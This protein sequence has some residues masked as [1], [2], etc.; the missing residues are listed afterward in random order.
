MI[1]FCF[2]QDTKET[3]LRQI[4]E[5]NLT[6]NAKKLP[7]YPLLQKMVLTPQGLREYTQEQTVQKCGTDV[8]AFFVTQ[9]PQKVNRN[10]LTGEMTFIDCANIRSFNVDQKRLD[11]IEDAYIAFMND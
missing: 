11:A 9:D 6:R 7:T 1:Q 8:K 3:Q 5:T 2:N 4:A 10:I